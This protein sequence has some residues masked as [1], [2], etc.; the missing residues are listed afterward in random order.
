MPSR[1]AHVILPA[2]LIT[3]M[4]LS[5]S[6]AAAQQGGPGGPGG[7][8]SGF[9]IT[10][11]SA[12]YS[13]ST[14]GDVERDGVVGTVEASHYGVSV[15]A[16]LPA[17][18]TW[19]LSSEFSWKRHEFDLTG[20]IPLPDE[21]DEFGINFM[22]MKD[23]SHEIGEGWSA[24]AMLSPSFA[25]DSS[26]FSGDSLSLFGMLAIGKEVSPNFSWNVGIVG[27]TRGDMKV[28]PMLGVHW[29]FAPDWSLDLGFPE[30]GISY[31]VSE[32][33]RLSLKASFEGGTYYV[34]EAPAPGF[35]DTY[36]DYQEIRFGLGVD[37]QISDKLSIVVEGGMVIDRTF[38]Y[39][40]EDIEFEGESAAYGRLS[41]RYQF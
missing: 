34:S 33:L 35:G 32:A 31:Q 3:S 24:M 13:F 15:S 7:G 20:T 10:D 41:L 14:E 27:M 18:D 5:A 11:V 29:S 23:L 39:Y 12:T 28:L 9:A 40:E 8:P 17:P 26:D 37:Y 4:C 19:M 25:S 36:L 2:T 16:S 1:W 21:L 30:T 6:N 22:A 38:D